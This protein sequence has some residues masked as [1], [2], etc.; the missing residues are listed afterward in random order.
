MNKSEFRVFLAVIKGS[1]SLASISKDTKISI[2]RVSQ[3]ISN[4]VKSGFCK[5]EIKGRFVYCLISDTGFVQEIIKFINETPLFKSKEFLTGLNLRI[6]SLCVFSPKSSEVLAKIL[7]TSQKAVRNRLYVLKN[8]TA[9]TSKKGFYIIDRKNHPHLA[10]FLEQYRLFYPY[11]VNIL[12][13]FENEVIYETENEKEIKGVLTGLSKYEELK[14]PLYFTQFCC[15]VPKK[16]LSKE[17]IFVHSILEMGDIRTIELGL[18]FSL[19]HKM[20]MKRL[21][22]LAEKYDCLERLKD[23]NRILRLEKPKELHSISEK[24][25]KEV[26]KQYKVKWKKSLIKR[27]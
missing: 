27:D 24:E 6:L 2:S 22:K 7:K 26:F 8:V 21:K 15:Y 18:I 3:I 1:N 23:L 17:E 10:K 5:K 9:L 12:W 25:L 13:K 16:K 20:S 19:K 4:L 14:V 11:P